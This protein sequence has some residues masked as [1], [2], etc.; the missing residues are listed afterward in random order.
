M[1][2]GGL[3]AEQLTKGEK[4]GGHLVFFVMTKNVQG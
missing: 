3:D 4:S 2:L 1:F